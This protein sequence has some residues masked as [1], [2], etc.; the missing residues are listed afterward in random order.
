MQ[1]FTAIGRL[2]RDVE[3]RYTSD[4]SKKVG[5]FTLAINNGKKKD[6]SEKEPLF[7]NCVVFDGAAENFEKYVRKGSKIY[8][9]GKLE[10][11]NYTAKD[12]TKVYG[13]C[14]VVDTYEFLDNKKPESND[15][16]PTQY[17]Q[18]VSQTPYAPQMPVASG[19]PTLP[20]SQQRA[21]YF[22]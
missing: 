3:L 14:L 20:S 19:T 2:T 13:V 5:R 11:D 16:A 21:T 18:P 8:L 22:G 7:V 6:G 9:S 10:P 4:A 1:N 12:G 15:A 17:A